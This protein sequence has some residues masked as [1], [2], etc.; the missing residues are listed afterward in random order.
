MSVFGRKWLSGE[1]SG[2]KFPGSRAVRWGFLRDDVMTQTGVR[3]RV[4]A[5]VFHPDNSGV[6]VDIYKVKIRAAALEMSRSAGCIIFVQPLA[7]KSR[8]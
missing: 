7:R 6:T 8:L 2:K 3:H 5:D 1:S 4:Y